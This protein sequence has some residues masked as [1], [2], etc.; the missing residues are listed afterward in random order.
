MF[1]MLSGRLIKKNRLKLAYKQELI[2]KNRI[3]SGLSR[4]YTTAFVLNLDT[5][6]YE[7]V[8][9]QRQIMPRNMK[10]SKHFQIMDVP[11]LLHLHFRNFVT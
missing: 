7:F 3:L 4:D 5:D 9:N 8:F 10:S 2:K 1:C 11:M 6:E